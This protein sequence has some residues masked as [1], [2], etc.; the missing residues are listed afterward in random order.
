MTFA[1]PVSCATPGDDRLFEHVL[2]L[3]DPRALAVVERRADVDLDAVVTSVLD[4]AQREHARPA[5][6]QLEHLLVG[7]LRELARVGD[8]ARVGAVDAVDVGVDLAR[9]RRSSA[10][11]SATAVVSE[12]PRPSVVMSR[13]GRDALEARD[14]RDLPLVERLAGRGSLRIST[15]FALPWRVS[16]TIP[17]CEPVNETASRPRSLI[18][19][20]TSAIEIRSP[21]V[22][23]MSCSRGCGS[24]ETSRASAIS[25]SVVS[26]I[27]ET[28]TQTSLPR[29]GRA[30][31][32][33][34][35]PA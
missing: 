30:R 23:S 7:D 6:R 11:A 34:A 27:A 24:G 14:D 33:G 26:P 9:R 22:S 15:I 17:A 19:I 31:R 2:L 20:E 25:R 8:D 35:R 1:S 13:R 18:A 21:E 29:L 5:R 28:T 16:V 10:A 3:D 12:P 4:R 32:C